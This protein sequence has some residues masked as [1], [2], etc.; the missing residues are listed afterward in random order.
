[1]V[2]I[3]KMR[4]LGEALSGLGKD[5]LMGSGAGDFFRGGKKIV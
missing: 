1:M 4:G 2:S 5:A 3:R